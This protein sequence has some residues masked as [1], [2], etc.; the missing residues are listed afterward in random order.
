MKT[1]FG[2]EYVKVLK[3]LMPCT[4]V[5]EHGDLMLRHDVDNNLD[6][7][8]GM[9]RIE[10]AHGVRSTYY[11]LTPAWNKSNY[12]GEWT[13]TGFRFSD[14]ALVGIGQ[15]LAA[16]HEVG[17]HNNLLTVSRQSSIP[18]L[19]LLA[20]MVT[21]FADL[22][23][24]PLGVASHGDREAR[25]DGY[26]NYDFLRCCDL[27][28]LGVAYEAYFLKQQR[29]DDYLSD[30]GGNLN[31]KLEPRMAEWNAALGALRRPAQVLL[32]PWWWQW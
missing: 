28:D 27:A 18:P 24:A 13:L 29:G 32:H 30:S 15:L 21:A 20:R 12:L 4:P 23:I 10:E 3:R 26:I 7:A 5:I 17:Y 6:I 14:A 31:N 16:G 9:A 11:L 25:R 2:V 1:R 19:T 8:L 22:G